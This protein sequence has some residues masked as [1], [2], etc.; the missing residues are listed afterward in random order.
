[1]AHWQ[2]DLDNG[3]DY[4]FKV[5]MIGD[6][7]VGK[8]QLL[9]RFAKDEFKINSR[10]TIGVEF[11]SKTVVID[12]K[13]IKAQIWDTAGQERYQAITSAYYRGAT[14]AMLVYD[15]SKRRTFDDVEKWLNELRR[16]ADNHVTMMLIGNKTDLQSLRE[17][18]TEEAK[19][20]AQ[21]EDLFFME[22]S[23]LDSTN[24]DSAFLAVLSQIYRSVTHRNVLPPYEDWNNIILG[25]GIPINPQLPERQEENGSRP[26]R[27]F[28]HCCNF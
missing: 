4:M 6:P 7:S 5:V 18:P 1:M 27:M 3:I 2:N 14:G 24:V 9:S 8:T 11:Q 16:Y 21:R 23:A 10:A 22:T 15:I 12:H 26:K 28:N 13:T 19:E 17:V 20:L 25:K